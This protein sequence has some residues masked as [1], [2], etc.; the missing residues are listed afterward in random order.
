MSPESTAALGV[1]I[2][3][4]GFMGK[5]HELA[6]RDADAAG[7]SNRVLCIADARDS[8]ETDVEHTRDPATLFARDDI[9]LVSICTP[10]PTHV[11]LAERAL[12]A[13]KHVLVEKPVALAST[14]VRRLAKKA[15]SASTLCMPAMCMRFWPGWDTLA[16]AVR[17]ACYGSVHSAFFQRLSPPPNWSQAF[18]SDR[19]LSGGAL[20][21]LHIHDADF[22]QHLFGKPSSVETTGTHDHSMTRYT[23]ANGPEDVRAEGGWC[24]PQDGQFRMRYEVVFEA[25]TL[26]YDSSRDAPLTWTDGEGSRTVSIAATEG[27]DGEV[28]HLLQAIRSGTSDLDATL[29]DAVQLTETLEAE[30]ESLE[31]GKPVAL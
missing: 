1:G 11:E 20:F 9:E 27:Y 8:L 7:Y 29:E 3:G 25:G 24:L 16:E 28:R 22:V 15:A 23:F 14:D 10:T 6:Y 4:H 30:R 2:I 12:D 13:G 31:S 21:D 19:S 26:E 5:R 18:Y 17:D